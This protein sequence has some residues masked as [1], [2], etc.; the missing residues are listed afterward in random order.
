MKRNIFAFLLLAALVFQSAAFAQ[1]PAI[2]I[3]PAEKRMVESVTAKQ[4][5]DY[6]HFVASDEME[7]R[8]TPSR[9]LDLTAKFIATN[10]SR[11]GVRPAGDDGTYFQKIALDREVVDTEK[12]VLSINGQALKRGDDFLRL[13]GDRAVSAP[14]V[15]GGHGWM[16]KSKGVDAYGGVDVKGKIVVLY[17][18]QFNPSTFTTLP[19]GVT[20]ADISGKEGVDW[21]DPLTYASQSGAVGIIAIAPP[22]F[23]ANW[24]TLKN[25][26]SGGSLYPQ[27]LRPSAA[28]GSDLPMLL[29]SQ[30]AGETILAGE[31][32]DR[33]SSTA[34]AINKTAN[35]AAIAK[36]EIVWT[37]NVVA[38]WEGSDPVLKNEMVSIGAHYAHDGIK[39]TAKGDDKI[40]NG[41]DD[42]GSGTVAVLSIA[43]A[44]ANSPVRPKRSI[45]FVW[46]CGE[47]KGLWGSEYFNKFPTVDIKNVIAQLNIDMIGRSKKAGDTN[48]KNKELTADNE[49]YVIGSEMMSSTL[50]A[51]T[52]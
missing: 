27:K 5:S 52:K 4:L 45:L 13:R 23:Q 8:D 18:S 15:F 46:H 6:L 43:E 40:Y 39:L 20:E 7:G 38:L 48:P 2:K 25:Y 19:E 3:T 16:V 29:V 21:A 30:P 1:A 50:G 22:A 42:D 51:I 31:S 9:G 24:N 26:F 49:I 47:E 37:Q 44:L 32:G 10:L 36:K 17:S 34:F 11:W 35:M 28:S 12:T 41:A 14:M 33:T